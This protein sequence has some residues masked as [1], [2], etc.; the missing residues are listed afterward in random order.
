MR[1]ASDVGI[2]ARNCPVRMIFARYTRSKEIMTAVTHTE[3]EYDEIK[4][5]VCEWDSLMP[6]ISITLSAGFFINVEYK[7]EG[8]VESVYLTEGM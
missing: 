6:L 8:T 7:Y 1:L 3:A 5:C 2:S 4:S